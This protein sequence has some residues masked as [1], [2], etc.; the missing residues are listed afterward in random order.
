MRGPSRYRDG[1]KGNIEEEK[2]TVYSANCILWWNHENKVWGKGRGGGDAG[3][4]EEG[5]GVLR[6]GLRGKEKL[7]AQASSQFIGPPGTSYMLN[8]AAGSPPYIVESQEIWM[9]PH[10]IPMFCPGKSRLDSNNISV[11]SWHTELQRT[12]LDCSFL[13]EH[14]WKEENIL[15]YLWHPRKPPD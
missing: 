14:F 4:R 8:Q 12:S 13:K 1:S 6:E 5:E 7:A 3:G 9:T 10:T 11:T 2:R 15:G